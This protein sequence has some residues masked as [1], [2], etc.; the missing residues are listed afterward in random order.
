MINEV[1]ISL[2][3]AVEEYYAASAKKQTRFYFGNLVDSLPGLNAVAGERKI[4]TGKNNMR[5]TAAAD[6][7]GLKPGQRYSPIELLGA[8][9]PKK[10]ESIQVL[11]A[12]EISKL[13][14]SKVGRIILSMREDTLNIEKMDSLVQQELSRKGIGVDYGL[15][16]TGP[17]GLEQFHNKHVMEK[18]SLSTSSKSTWLPSQTNLRLYFTNE[19][20][21]ILKQNIAGIFL[22]A[23][24]LAAVIGSLLFLLKVINNQKQLAEIKNDFISNLTHEFK[25]PIA[26]IR[27]AMEGILNF[28]KNN[29]PYKTEKYVKASYAQVEKL[30]GMVEKLLEVATLNGNRLELRKEQIDVVALARQ[31]ALK[32][33]NLDREK[34][35]EIKSNKQEIFLMADAFHLE[36]VFNNI[37]DNAFKY[38]GCKIQLSLTASKDKIKIICSDN[39]KNLSR[40]QSEQIFEKFYRVPKGNTHDVKGYGIGLYYSR[41]IIDRHG[42]NIKAEAEGNTNIIIELPYE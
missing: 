17:P 18:A 3:N 1:Q 22:S 2:D 20:A 32:F 34:E 15:L 42:G 30:D 35:F 24:L 19:T 23:L 29:D 13:V 40:S 36:N 6:S 31:Q 12:D 39:G 25:T 41:Q 27:V 7:A 14:E 28:N 9:D 4:F 21:T 10:I 8:V 38:G 11:G 5:L 16:Y 26:T 33:A 37:L